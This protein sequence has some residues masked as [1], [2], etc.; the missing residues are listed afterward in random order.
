MENVIETI[1]K[2]V[3]L[4]SSI[5]KRIEV[6]RA[7][8]ADARTILIQC[9]NEI[10]YGYFEGDSGVFV[11]YKHRNGILRF[12]DFFPSKRNQVGSLELFFRKPR[13]YMLSADI[14][15]MSFLSPFVGLMQEAFQ[16]ERIDKTLR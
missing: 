10:G 12:L 11:F 6:L 13:I 7:A 8:G 1:K 5:H 2:K 16:I 14:V 9:L 3:A 15:S 4:D